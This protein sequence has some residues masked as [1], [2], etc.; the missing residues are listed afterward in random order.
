[1]AVTHYIVGTAGHIDHGKSSL[2]EALSGTNPDRLPEEKARGMT[3]DLGFA[4]LSLPHPDKPQEGISVGL[5]D[6]PGHADFVKNMVAGVGSIDVALFIVA[7]DDGWMPQTEEH[8]QI[9]TYLGVQRAVVAMT[10]ADLAEDVE[11]SVELVREALVGTIFA[12]APIVPTAAPK[13]IGIAELKETL[14][15]VLAETP[16]PKDIGK[17]RLPVDRTFSPTGI[18]TVVTGTLTGG[19]LERGQA[20]VIQPSGQKSHVRGLQSHSK[21]AQLAV[22]GTRTAVNVADVAIAQRGEKGGVSRGDVITLATLGEASDTLDVLLEKSAREV[23]G[24]PHATRQLRNGQKVY[25]HHGGANCEG[26]FYFLGQKTLEPGQSILAQIRFRTP[27]YAFY[28]DRFVVRD[29]SKQATIAGGIILDPDGQR[30]SFRKPTQRQYLEKRAASITS[31]ADSLLAQLE[32]DRVATRGTLLLKSHF[33]QA[34]VDRTLQSLLA[35]KVVLAEG[36]TLLHEPWWKERLDEAANVINAFQKAQPHLP[37]MDL[38]DLASHMAASLPDRK[39]VDALV[40]QLAERGFRR[41]G[42]FVSR[43]Q[44]Q[45]SLPGNLVQAGTR[46]RHALAENPFEPPGIADL[47]KT[48]TDRQA[49]KFLVDNKEAVTL[50]EKA[51]VLATALQ[52]MQQRVVDYLM[53][54]QQAT[55]S[56]LRQVLGTTRRILVP[57]ME[58]LDKQGVTLRN[59]DIRTLK[60]RK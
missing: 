21:N 12:D 47:I 14:A 15:R 52:E 34:E 45:L 29:F 49:L 18:G 36:N 48:P 10:K 39:L 1:M 51:V 25:F 37:G 13:G 42:Q 7:A 57:L 56:D 26:R 9:L 59:G 11:F 31:I 60:Q 54:H 43:G 40:T 20:I 38:G 30:A 5:I 33:L 24:N 22:P 16:P 58:R 19:V 4:H 41:S 27:I 3:I 55:V 35:K 23:P 32:R 46:I 17:P 28:G 53:Q 2:V 50:D 8:L 44:H 6:V